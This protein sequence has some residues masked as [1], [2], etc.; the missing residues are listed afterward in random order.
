MK[1]IKQDKSTGNIQIVVA[2]NQVSIKQSVDGSLNWVICNNENTRELALSICPE[3]AHLE[4]ALLAEQE[5]NNQLKEEIERLKAQILKPEDWLSK[6]DEDQLIWL[7]FGD[8]NSMFKTIYK[9]SDRNFFRD[10]LRTAQTELKK[11]IKP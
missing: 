2:V 11:R 3:L 7:R 4:G 10:G 6:S 1:V 9:V 8:V 5:L